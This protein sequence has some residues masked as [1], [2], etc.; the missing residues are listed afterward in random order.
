MGTG[1]C[2]NDNFPNAKRLQLTCIRKTKSKVGHRNLMRQG[3]RGKEN[4]LEVENLHGIG[5]SQSQNM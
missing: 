1:S 4:V 2:R 3:T 5:E